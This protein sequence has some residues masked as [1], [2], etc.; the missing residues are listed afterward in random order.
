MK[1]Q[2]GIYFIENLV[3]GKLYVGQASNLSKRKHAHFAELNRNRHRNKYL[4][5]A[6][7]KYGEGSFSF[8]IVLICELKELTY[9]EQCLID[10]INSVYNICR[11]CVDSP[12]GV[13][14]SDETKKNVSLNHAD[15]AG[16]NHPMF[17]KKYKDAS[18]KYLG[19]YKKHLKW[20]GQIGYMRKQFYLGSYKTENEAALAYNKKIL[21]LCGENARINIIE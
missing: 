20:A 4:Q 10:K 3:N 15:M 12:L 1:Q 8:K 11:E 21:E 13:K 2:S 19:V 17:G 7:N 18:S 14:R 6:F 9:Y 5:N 16:V